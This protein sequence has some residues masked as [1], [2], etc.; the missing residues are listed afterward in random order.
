MD[1]LGICFNFAQ[2][3][4]AAIDLDSNFLKANSKFL[5]MVGYGENEIKNKSLLECILPQNVAY[6][7]QR[8][9]NIITQNEAE[10]LECSLITKNGNVVA[11]NLNITLLE[12]RQTALISVKESFKLELDALSACETRFKTIFKCAN[13]GIV[14]IDSRGDILNFND[15]FATLTGYSQKELR[16]MNFV[17]FTHLEDYE[18]ERPLFEDVISGKRDAYAIEKRFVTKD[19]DIVWVD[20]SVATVRDC[21][22]KIINFIGTATD[23]TERKNLEASS[24]ENAETLSALIEHAASM[25]YIKDVTGKYKLVN[26]QFE[27]ITDTNRKQIIG[28]TD[29]DIFSKHNAK[30]F[31]ENDLKVLNTQK[32][33]EVE[34]V[35]DINNKTRYFLS[36]KFPMKSHCGK[37][38]GV[39]GIASEITSQ[40]LEKERLHHILEE[41]PVGICL[42][43]DNKEI[44]FKNRHFL[45]LLGIENEHNEQSGTNATLCLSNDEYKNWASQI[46]DTTIT[47]AKTKNI[48]AL[49]HEIEIACLDGRI[50][51]VQLFG[52]SFGFDVL[53]TVVDFT[54]HKE[55]ENELKKA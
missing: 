51:T 36:V 33:I 23:I 19:G 53:V 43:N 7:S 24:K 25:I 13:I 22:K 20:I 31:R 1:N 35:L 18:L 55:Y 52:I 32:S 2:E 49:P 54:K 50:R 6:V 48:S 8:L 4:F 15:Y 44:Y 47:N 37:I 45:E 12:D 29:D 34:E 41:M 30:Q 17:A 21:S 46:W 16:C 9:S 11:V 5:K 27:K 42:L 28:K 26:S 14:F 10:N 40:K 38:D 39:C 3:G